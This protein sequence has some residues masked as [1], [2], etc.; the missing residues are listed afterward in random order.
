MRRLAGEWFL[1]GEMRD[2]AAVGEEETSRR[3][4]LLQRCCLRVSS[5]SL[6]CCCSALNQVR[7][8][9]SGG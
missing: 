9:V 5:S 6:F 7:M 8:L 4:S 1:A 3:F 2:R